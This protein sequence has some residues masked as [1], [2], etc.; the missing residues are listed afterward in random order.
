MEYAIGI[1]VSLIVEALKR[2]AGTDSL[3]THLMLAAIALVGSS[4]YVWLSADTML[5]QSFVQVVLV[6]STFHNLIL[7]KM[8][9][10]PQA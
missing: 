9:S 7:R 8:E 10:S 1:V 3:M 4:L 6:A 2:Y 5:W